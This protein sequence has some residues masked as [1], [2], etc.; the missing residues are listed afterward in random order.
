MS[1]TSI[2]SVFCLR[3]IRTELGVTT[4]RIFGI[5]TSLFPY[6][7][8]SHPVSLPPS[9]W[10]SRFLFPVCS[11]IISLISTYVH[12]VLTCVSIEAPSLI[13]DAIKMCLLLFTLLL[14]STSS[15]AMLLKRFRR[16]LAFLRSEIPRSQRCYLVP[17]PTSCSTLTHNNKLIYPWL[18]GGL[19]N[20][21]SI[22]SIWEV[23]YNNHFQWLIIPRAK[24]PKDPISYHTAH[25]SDRWPKP[26]KAFL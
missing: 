19:W 18:L 15:K 16:D 17:R 11:K 6:S 7:S 5:H 3:G 2:L 25:K 9:I 4:D 8:P 14:F 13:E 24:Q 21:V 1:L 23:I 22:G 12:V 20:C 26:G 10:H